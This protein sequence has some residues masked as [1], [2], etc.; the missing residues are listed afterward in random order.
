MTASKKGVFSVELLTGEQMPVEN[1]T[2][3]EQ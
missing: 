2:C 1:V 3:S